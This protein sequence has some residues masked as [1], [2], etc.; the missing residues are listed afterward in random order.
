MLGAPGWP[1]PRYRIQITD[2]T[3]SRTIPAVDRETPPEDCDLVTVQEAPSEKL[4][5]EWA[6]RVWDARYGADARPAQF[7]LAI[8]RLDNIVAG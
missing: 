1:M 5:K 6:W 3:R 2:M 4:A 7:R 8:T